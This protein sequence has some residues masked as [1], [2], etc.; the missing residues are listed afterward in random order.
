MVGKQ[1]L[2]SRGA[3]T[4]FSI[5]N[6]VA[7]YFAIIPALSAVVDQAALAVERTNLARDI[8]EKR[9]LTETESLRAAL[10][11][12]IS[13]DL[14]T[15]LVSI[16]GSASS[17]QAYGERIPPAQRG[18]LLETIQDEAERLNRFVQNLLDMTRLGYGALMP[19]RDWVDLRDVIGRARE[20]LKKP[21]AAF[22]LSVDFAEE[23][24]LLHV[25]AVLMEQVMVN[26]LDNAAKY[27]PPGTPISVTALPKDG[28]VEVRVCDRGPGIPPA[29]RE[30][31]FDMFYRVRSGDREKAG[32]GLG[33]AIC[34]GIVEAHGGSI[35]VEDGAD[36]VGAAIAVTLPVSP[37]QAEAGEAA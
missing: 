23:L 30:A 12:S 15:P 19:K 18:E 4:T 13:H 29:D 7:K 8:E 1:M 20:R 17:L 32:T 14:R 2:I 22:Q 21:L 37:M 26:L 10:L 33:L 24:P 3:L 5:A 36:G 6:D 28:A 11:S 9:L 34:R 16:I 31:V 35:R 27:A 25:D